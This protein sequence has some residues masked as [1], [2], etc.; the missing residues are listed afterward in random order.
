MKTENKLFKTL[1]KFTGK[2]VFIIILVASLSFN[3]A[4]LLFDSVYALASG[5]VS[6][7]SGIRSLVV[8]QA[9]EISDLNAK[10]TVEKKLQREVK[11]ELVSTS[12]EL[13]A[14]RLTTSTL[15]S[16]LT[17]QTEELLDANAKLALEK[18][19]NREVKTELAATTARLTAERA[20]TRT[21]RSNLAQ[22]TAE[23]ASLKNFRSK[24]MIATN[25][26]AEKI[27]Q[28]TKRAALRDV[29]A[30]PAEAIP[31]WG[32]AVIV[33]ATTLELADMCLNLVDMT[34]LQKFFDPTYKASEDQLTVC[35]LEV[36][37]KEEIV[38]AVKTS[39]SKVWCSAVTTMPT[40]TELKNLELP[41]VDWSNV[42][43]TAKEK[44]SEITDTVVG[45]TGKKIN[46]IVDWWSGD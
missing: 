17:Q 21:V 15:R 22:K 3:A 44:V 24:A 6:T 31:F 35:S 43:L 7:A 46:Q 20:T 23:I 37:S 45:T 19:L 14:E 27:A 36:P 1:F 8:R 10:L 11:T 39:P 33:T 5:A 38:E 26:A 29:A 4:M 42:T 34:N 40:A 28:R 18:K 30:M 41:D 16:N 13:A 9:D 25:N 12:S 2:T 32:T